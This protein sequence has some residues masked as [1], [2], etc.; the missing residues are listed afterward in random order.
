M[1]AARAQNDVLYDQEIAQAAKIGPETQPY[2]AFLIYALKESTTC[3]RTGSP[4]F[5]CFSLALVTNM[6]STSPCAHSE[7]SSQ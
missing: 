3:L 6:Y 7:Q 1:L 5:H 4:F 2:Q